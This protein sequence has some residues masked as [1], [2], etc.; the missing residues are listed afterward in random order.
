MPTCATI[1]ANLRHHSPKDTTSQSSYN[2]AAFKSRSTCAWVTGGWVVGEG[3]FGHLPPYRLPQPAPLDLS[4]WTSCNPYALQRQRS[5]RHRLSLLE[6]NP[7]R[8]KL[9]IITKVCVTQMLHLPDVLS[10]YGGVYKGCSFFRCDALEIDVNLPTF[11]KIIFIFRIEV[12]RAW[13]W[14]Q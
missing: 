4:A 2:M 3:V 7:V 11:Q 12:Y 14:R 10:V 8:R 13:T 6:W 9:A 1:S 5:C